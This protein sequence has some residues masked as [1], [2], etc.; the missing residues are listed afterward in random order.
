MPNL[1]QTFLDNYGGTKYNMYLS[2]APG[3]INII[4]EHT[5][6]NDGFVFPC[7]L[8]RHM[9]MVFRPRGDSIVRCYAK[10]LDEHGTCDLADVSDTKALP[11]F[12]QYVVGSGIFLSKEHNG[13]KPL[14]GFDAVITSLIPNGGGVSSSSALCVAS[15]MCFR[16]ANP[17]L[18]VT[19]EE[20]LLAIC[21]SEWFYSGVRGGIMDQYS[22]LNAKE[23][24]AFVLD[25]RTQAMHPDFTNIPFPKGV[26][27]LI[28]NTN[29]KHDLVGTPYNDRRASCEEAAAAIAKAFPGKN[30]THL[31]DANLDMLNKAKP[32]MRPVAYQRACHVLAEDKRTIACAT[33]LVKGDLKT[34]GELVNQSHNSLRDLYEVSCPEL[35]HMVEAARGLKG[36]YGARMM[37]GGFGGCAI[38][39]VQDKYAADVVP[40][41]HNEY[42]RRTNRE[43]HILPS[44]PGSG[45][46]VESLFP[47]FDTPLRA[48]L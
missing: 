3:R 39:L 31:R 2:S 37:G 43:P 5:D 21:Q 28:A 32:Q 42:K 41:L 26:T 33:A 47:R 29:V 48:H 8:D 40:A 46:S 13:G 7:G 27:I 10:D 12:L 36:V 23:G 45:A 44:R 20:F 9:L 19:P 16:T 14:N 15:A 17:A 4:G 30:V 11:R 22:S 6:Y 38:V 25:C 18:V 34:A 1:V 35:D 24:C